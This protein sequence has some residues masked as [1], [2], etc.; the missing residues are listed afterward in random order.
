MNKIKHNTRILLLH[1]FNDLYEFFKFVYKKHIFSKNKYYFKWQYH[2]FEIKLNILALKVSGK[3]KGF[4]FFIPM[5]FFDKKL[6]KKEIFLTNF[7]CD[8]KIIGGGQIIFKNLISILKPDFIGTTGFKDI[9][10][11]YHKKLGFKVGTLEHYYLKRK[12]IKLNKFNNLSFKLLNKK[13]ISSINEKIFAF[14]TPT[15]S[16][17][18]IINRYLNHPIYKYFIYTDNKKNSIMIFREIKFR[19]KKIL[20]IIDFFGKSSSFSNYKSLFH[21]LIL[22]Q[23]Y[24]SIDIYCYGIK[25]IILKKSGLKKN[26]NKEVVPEFYEPFVNKNIKL[27]FGYIA[28]K[29]IKNVRLFKGDGDRDRPSI[30]SLKQKKKLNFI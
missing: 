2:A 6:S 9:M 20:K 7:Y 14:Q 12:M 27:N 25:K 11:N 19:N 10:I 16:K 30:I 15:K 26:Y 28:N 8:P 17:K 23:G 24:Y 21:F 13:D 18:F 1:E 4:Q 22:T 29:N 3:I 5:N